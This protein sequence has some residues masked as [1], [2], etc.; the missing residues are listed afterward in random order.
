MNTRAHHHISSL[1]A[2][3]AL[4]SILKQGGTFHL[5]QHRA[6]RAHRESTYS[7]AIEAA[8]LHRTIILRYVYK[9]IKAMIL[10]KAWRMS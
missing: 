8:C 6:G 4:C 2:L 5:D 10:F 3:R 9:Y 7:P 1:C